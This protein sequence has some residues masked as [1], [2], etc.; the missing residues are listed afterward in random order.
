MR[1]RPDGKAAPG[2]G[3]TMSPMTKHPRRPRDPNQLGKLVL[4]IATGETQDPPVDAGK[5]AKMAALGR[6]GGASGG[7]ARAERLTAKERSD[8]AKQAAQARW[9]K[10]RA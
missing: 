3:C 2:D 6:K 5:D 10:Q 4:D 8:A 1:E 7:K 9:A